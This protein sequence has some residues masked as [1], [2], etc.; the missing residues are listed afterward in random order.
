MLGQWA[1]ANGFGADVG[2]IPADAPLPADLM[3]KRSSEADLRKRV[4]EC[5]GSAALVCGR[6]SQLLLRLEHLAS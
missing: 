4:G 2:A 6:N 3:E 5:L 1:E